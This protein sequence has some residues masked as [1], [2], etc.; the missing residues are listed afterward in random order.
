V[1]SKYKINGDSVSRK[2]VTDMAEHFNLQVENP[3]AILTQV[4]GAP[5]LI[6]V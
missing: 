6:F 5:V 1:T 3:C 4:R 2:E